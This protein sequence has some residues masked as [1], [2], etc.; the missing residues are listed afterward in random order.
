MEKI[1]AAGQDAMFGDEDFAFDLHLE[2]FGVDT[3]ALRQPVVQRIFRAY[4]EDWEQEAR[5]KNDCVAEARLLAKYKGLVF[6][7]PDT[8]MTF[9]VYDKNMEFCRGR[10]NGWFVLA[11]SSDQDT[12]DD[13]NNEYEAFLLEVACEVIGDTPQSD[14]IIVVHEG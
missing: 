6:V 7:D 11:V 12:G 4:V 5:K 9:S 14:G 1:D 10:G 13:N 8:G 2:Q 3:A